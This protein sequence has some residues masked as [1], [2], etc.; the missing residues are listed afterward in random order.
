MIRAEPSTHVLLVLT[1]LDL[2]KEKSPI[3]QCNFSIMNGQ[4]HDKSVHYREGSS[5]GSSSK[6]YR[7][8]NINFK[9][10]HYEE[11]FI[12]EKFT[13]EK[14]HY[15]LNIRGY[16]DMDW[17]YKRYNKCG[18]YKRIIRIKKIV[19]SEIWCKRS[20]Q[21]NPTRSAQQSAH[22]S[23][24]PVS[25]FLTRQ[26]VFNPLSTQPNSA[27][28]NVNPTQP[29]PCR[30]G[31][32]LRLFT[33]VLFVNLFHHNRNKLYKN[34]ENV[35]IIQLLRNPSIVLNAMLN[36]NAG[37]II[38]FNTT[39]LT[40][41]ISEISNISTIFVGLIF[42]T[43]G[44]TL[45][46]CLS[47]LVGAIIIGPIPGIPLA[48]AILVATF[49]DAHREKIKGMV[50]CAST[51]SILSSMFT[52]SEAMGDFVGP[53]I[54][55]S[56]MENLGYDWATVPLCLFQVT[57]ILLILAIKRYNHVVRF[58]CLDANDKNLYERCLSDAQCLG[59]GSA[60]DDVNGDQTV[61]CWQ[62]A[63]QC[64]CA[65]DYQDMDGECLLIADPYDKHECTAA[66]PCAGKYEACHKGQC[67]CAPNYKYDKKTKG[68]VKH[69][70]SED[71]H[72]RQLDDKHMDCDKGTGMCRC[73]KGYE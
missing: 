17:C 68:C 9:T 37:S 30:V 2:G 32:G 56:F 26:P 41:H 13:Q 29:N 22:F 63:G 10:V 19:V 55:G 54:G 57:L 3:P 20:T 15:L 64:V 12:Q 51:T 34:T 42:F 27:F 66:K 25:L 49:A 73:D 52:T 69:K 11:V 61:F 36:L 23:P 67:K 28:E 33:M 7:K 8:S 18:I 71:K 62:T 70:C 53:L 24:Q 14:L 60:A 31:L 45:F 46:G 47:I 5:K 59:T 65:D 1:Q 44:F 21:P 72:C 16:R 35:S 48:P 39:T 38:G 6:N 58:D 40:L 43:S 4:L 50:T